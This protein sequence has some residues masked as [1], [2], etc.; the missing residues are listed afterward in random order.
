MALSAFFGLRPEQNRIVIEQRDR[1]SDVPLAESNDE[2][3]E[4]IIDDCGDTC[5]RFNAWSFSNS[6]CSY[7]AW[8]A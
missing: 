1:A 6:V 5:P 4:E 8:L 2:R 3:A 7:S